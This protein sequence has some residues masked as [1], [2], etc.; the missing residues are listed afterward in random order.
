MAY[1]ADDSTD[2]ARPTANAINTASAGSASQA[3]GPVEAR[4]LLQPRLG[5]ASATGCT[6]DLRRTSADT[7]CG[8]AYHGPIN[9][10]MGALSSI[11]EQM[12]L[13]QKGVHRVRHTG[14]GAAAVTI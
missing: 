11:P 8:V 3:V 9:R 1:A 12:Q 7:A 6:R 13:V 5:V 2:A 14:Q 4:R 10:I